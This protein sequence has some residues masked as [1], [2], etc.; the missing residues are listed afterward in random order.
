MCVVV[1]SRHMRKTSVSL[2][3][4]VPRY[5]ITTPLLNEALAGTG[6]VWRLLRCGLCFLLANE[7][8]VRRTRIRR[9]T[10]KRTGLSNRLTNPSRALL[11]M[12]CNNSSDLLADGMR[13]N[14]S[15]CRSLRLSFFCGC[16]GEVVFAI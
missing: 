7:K 1:T 9:R 12:C 2:Y 6:G 4:I 8:L 15:L 10:R 5:T 16:E 13:A 14:A 11:A 3:T